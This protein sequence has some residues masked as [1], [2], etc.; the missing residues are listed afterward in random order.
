MS[1]KWVEEGQNVA[2]VTCFPNHPT[3]VIPRK[4]KGKFFEREKI[5]G[6]DIFRSYVYATP[7]KGFTKRIINHLSFT[8]SSII[9]SMKKIKNT[10]IIIVTSPQFFLIFSGYIF[11]LVKNKPFVLEIRDLWPE[12]AVSLGIL[13][14]KIIIK[15][16]E[17][18]EMFY[19]KKANKIIVV[20]EGIKRNLIHRG[21]DNNKIEIITNGVDTEIFCNE[22]SNYDLKKQLDLNDKFIIG[23]VGTHG[24]A[25]GLENIIYVA[26]KLRDDQGIHFLFVGE[27]AEKEKLIKL[28][29]K[30]ELN[31]VTFLDQQK[32]ENI[33]NFYNIIDVCIVHLKKIDLFKGAIPSK[34]FEIL[35]CATPIVAGIEGE[36]ADILNESGGAVVVEPENISQISKAI[37][38]LK[39]DNSACENMGIIGK[40]YVLKNYRRDMLANKYLRILEDLV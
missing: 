15:A 39:N 27:G 21:I 19:Y 16:L 7:N 25:Q 2:V 12:A 3:G 18:L 9:I 35:A 37:K 22:I 32:K 36:V 28:T 13:K 26:D 1:K 10:D 8:I 24:M 5:N 34:I 33:P 40:E 17:R 30:L 23:Y 31:N 4:Y 11:S 29:Q 38:T 20:T 14:N 6:I